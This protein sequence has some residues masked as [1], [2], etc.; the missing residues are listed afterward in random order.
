M[1]IRLDEATAAG[2][3]AEAAAAEVGVETLAQIWC[4]RP[5]V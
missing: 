5:I 1:L 2:A 4:I 3:K